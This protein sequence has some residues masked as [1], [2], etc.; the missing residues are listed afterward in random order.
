MV[1]CELICGCL[2]AGLCVLVGG[3]VWFWFDLGLDSLWF[4]YVVSMLVFSF[5]WI[6]CFDCICVNLVLFAL[7]VLFVDLFVVWCFEYRALMIVLFG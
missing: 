5:V 4:D 3:W 6:L 2:V 7:G 1:I